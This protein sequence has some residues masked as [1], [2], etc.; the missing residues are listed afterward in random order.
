MNLKFIGKNLN[1][2]KIFKLFK[3]FGISTNKELHK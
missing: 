2:G 3:K 1:Y